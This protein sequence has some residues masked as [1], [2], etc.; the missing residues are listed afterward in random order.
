M[1]PLLKKL[2]GILSHDHRATT[3][4]VYLCH[5]TLL[6]GGGLVETRLALDTEKHA[7]VTD[8]DVW[9]SGS[10]VAVLRWEEVIAL[11]LLNYL[12][13]FCLDGILRSASH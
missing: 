9:Y 4:L 8:D 2:D 7:S 3:G 5:L 13:A 12:N 10:S 6:Q 11:V 1:E